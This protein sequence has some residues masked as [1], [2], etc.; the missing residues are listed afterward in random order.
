VPAAGVL[1]RRES[2]MY[3]PWYYPLL[4]EDERRE[5]DEWLM[6][7]VAAAFEFYQRARR[8]LSEEK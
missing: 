5:F 7:E 4:N 3:R 2:S 6:S 8:M 1:P